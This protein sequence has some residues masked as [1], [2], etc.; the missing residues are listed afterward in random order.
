MVG[1]F[2]DPRVQYL[3]PKEK[4]EWAQL[5]QFLRGLQP[6][7]AAASGLQDRLFVI[8]FAN[9]SASLATDAGAQLDEVQQMNCY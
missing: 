9:G 5:Q 8:D 7:L 6:Q 4:E 3:S 1:S 2:E